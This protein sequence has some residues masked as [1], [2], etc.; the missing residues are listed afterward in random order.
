MD[1]LAWAAAAGGVSTLI[2]ARWPS[3]AF[4]L[5]AVE[6]SFHAELAKGLAPADA[7][8]AAVTAARETSPAPAGWA[9]LRLIGGQ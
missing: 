2:V 9:G 5:D 8:R 7:W 6:A 1:T 4:V 3:E